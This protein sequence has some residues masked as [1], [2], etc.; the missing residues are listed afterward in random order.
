MG[1]GK[2]NRML[3]CR[4]QY[5]AFWTLPFALAL[6]L[7][8]LLPATPANAQCSPAAANGVIATCSG[9]TV[10]QGDGA[11]GTSTRDDGY[12]GLG[13]AD[14]TV[15]VLPGASVTGNFNGIML[16][17]NTTIIND[18]S[19]TGT[20][21]DGLNIGTIASLIN[22][23]S[24]SGLE[25]GV[26]AGTITSLN[27]Q[28]SIVGDEDGV[29]AITIINLT[30]AGLI[31]GRVFAIQELGAGNT[32][33]TLLPGSVVR[34][35]IDLGGGVNTLNVGNGL[36]IANAFV[37]GA[38][39]VV[40]NGA[41]FAVNGNQV[42]VVDPTL[43]ALQSDMLVDLTNGILGGVSARLDGLPGGT[44]V[45]VTGQPSTHKVTYKGE[46]IA[47]VGDRQMWAHAFGA[48]RD[49][50]AGRPT[51]EAEHRLGGLMSGMDSQVDSTLRAGFFLGGSWG[52]AE[53]VLGTQD[54]DISTI[55]GGIYVRK[56]SGGLALDAALTLGHSEHERERQVANNLAPGG[57]QTAEGN[58]DGTFVATSLGLT[59]DVHMGRFRLNPGVHVRYA[60]LF[61]DGFTEAGATGNLALAERDIHTVQTRAQL[62]LPYEEIVDGGGFLKVEM[63]VGVE[64]RFNIGDDSFGAVLLGQN[65]GFAPGGDDTIASLFGGTNISYTLPNGR[66]QFTT[67]VEGGLEDDGS[68][69]LN[70]RAGAK[71]VF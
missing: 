51:V 64:G 53:S 24:I 48:A 50:E 34:G 30:N 3:S 27:N 15:T 68:H 18:G 63:K 36:S 43:E 29:E 31:Q 6:Y 58:F 14:V 44:V 9:Q 4:F 16:G 19:I 23:G 69:Y 55:F 10:D 49:Q 26:D 28:G 13:I 54:E 25:N 61:L 42:A 52:T 41:P 11:P 20:I 5:I 39:I 67:G 71:I 40:S 32:L 56:E 46:H 8:T 21:V 38:P 1:K 17:N 65:I 62:A 57:L 47:D 37:G 2:V 70:G 60:G 7:A 35:P 12:G 66:V 33:L 59:S 45:G 22:R